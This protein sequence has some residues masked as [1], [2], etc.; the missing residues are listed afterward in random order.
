M[1]LLLDFLFI[2]FGALTVAAQLVL[3][4]AYGLS[5]I[6]LPFSFSVI[7]DY[8]ATMPA[9]PTSSVIASPP[10]GS[11]TKVPSTMTITVVS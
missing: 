6:G 2:L 10:T 9:D 1:C 11:S 7:T 3:P 8:A 4:P 5:D